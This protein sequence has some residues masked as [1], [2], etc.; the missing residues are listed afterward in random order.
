M[1]GFTRDG[2]APNA[3]T[4][5]TDPLLTITLEDDGGSKG[6]YVGRIEGLPDAE[7]TFSRV[8]D[9]MMIIDHT[10]VPDEMRGLGVGRALVTKGVKDARSNGVKI[11]PLC[12]FAKGLFD[13]TPDWAD[14]RR[15]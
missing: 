11:I 9:T 12:P 4:P 14:V 13:R 8:G 2:F 5:M 1:R 6:R 3:E 15:A 7:M 10:A